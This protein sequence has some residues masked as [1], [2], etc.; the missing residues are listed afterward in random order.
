[1]QIH[2]DFWLIFIANTVAHVHRQ[3]GQLVRSL[4]AC[5]FRSFHDARG[6]SAVRS[7]PWVLYSAFGVPAT[8]A[9]KAVS[10]ISMHGKTGLRAVLVKVCLTG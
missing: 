3:A 6:R 8:G 2:D 4:T 9:N 1:M 10:Q 5:V 7:Q